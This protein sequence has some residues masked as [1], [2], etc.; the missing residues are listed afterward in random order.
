MNICRHGNVSFK[1]RRRINILWWTWFLNFN[2]NKLTHP[3]RSQRPPTSSQR[4]I[5][6]KV[7]GTGQYL[8]V[9]G[10]SKNSNP[11]F[12]S[13]Q[14][15]TT[16]HILMAFSDSYRTTDILIAK[17]LLCHY[18]LIFFKY[19]ILSIDWLSA[20]SKNICQ[21]QGLLLVDWKYVT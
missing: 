13:Q 14:I 8:H 12:L 4:P 1:S 9:Q 5:T 21:Q 16:D 15:Q 2:N 17:I 11:I 19:I 6:G 10:V 20:T 7:P 18:M 3:C